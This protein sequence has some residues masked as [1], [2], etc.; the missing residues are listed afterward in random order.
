MADNVAITAGT[1]T[2]IATDEV[3]GTSEHVQLFKIAVAADGSRVLVPADATD[4]LLVNL[5]AN[6]DVTVTSSA[7]PTGASTAARQDTGNTSLGN[8]DTKT[9]ALGQ[10]LAAASTP[11]VLTAAQVST[12]TPLATVA[13]THANLDVALSTLLAP[14]DTLAAVTTVGTITN[15]VTVA[16]ATAANLNVRATE[17]DPEY[18]FEW[19]ST[20]LRDRL[21]AQRYTVLSDSIADG[22][23]TFWT[24]T[25]AN[26]GSNTV[27]VGEGLIQTSTDVLGS[28]QISSTAPAYFPGQVAWLNSAI[29]LGD[30]G[31]V[32][33]VRRW[34][35]FTVSG[36]TPQDGFGYEL[37]GTTLNAVTWKAGVATTVASTSWSK[38]ATAP[39]TLDTNYH[40]FEIRWTANGANFYVD[41]VLRHSASGG[42]TAITTTLN[43]PI[44]I[45]SI[46]SSGA[47]NR[48][49]AVRNIGLGRFGQPDTLTSAGPLSVAKIRNSASAEGDVGI[50]SYTMRQDI[51]MR[52]TSADGHYGPTKTDKD[53][54]V[55][56]ASD[57]I[58]R[59]LDRVSMLL[60]AMAI[61][62]R[63]QN[64]ILAA[65][66]NFRDSLDTYRNDARLLTTIN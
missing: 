18:G 28:A 55:W 63:I 42:A 41:N 2:S 15:P 23:A 38:F 8:L 57:T 49:I 37:D 26:G 6:N 50:P 56:V 29:R 14:E 33:N 11:V 61:E 5:G 58:G 66:L 51:P 13:V 44:T 34:G 43:F 31:S 7:L 60:E 36:T 24:H 27:S 12:L 1:G 30:T 64:D 20:S 22:M 53:G 62:A 48:L 45:Q 32:G 59:Q 19:G 65:G 35:A 46:N 10:A 21:I 4:G 9:P 40:S 39:F 54:R 17:Y 52:T 3:T 25:T 16:Q 47:T